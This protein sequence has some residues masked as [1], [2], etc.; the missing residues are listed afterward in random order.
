ML[1]ISRI[2]AITL[3]LDDTLWPIL[4]VIEGAEAEL[5][6][7]LGLHAPATAR[8]FANV[9]ERLRLRQHVV[10]SR[11]DLGHNMSALRLEVI[12]QA[13]AQCGDDVMLAEP[14]F[15]VFF[16]A[17]MNVRL[18]ADA[19]PALAFLAGRYPLVALSNG[20]ADVNRVGI[21]HF[22]HASVSAHEFGV[23]KPDPRIFHA[24]AHSA[25]CATHEVLHIGDDAALDVHGAL[26]AGMQTVW[27]NRSSQPWH[28]EGTPHLSVQDLAQL[29]QHLNLEQR[30]EHQLT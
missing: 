20:N 21:G 19:L 23:G 27:V 9:P 3:D 25:H 11:P 18:F 5:A 1:D 29:V 7:W 28:H 6:R 17:R 14:A 16:E 4:P 30:S 24:A 26:A 22:F 15:E 8:V 13:L 10:S 2:K 12:R